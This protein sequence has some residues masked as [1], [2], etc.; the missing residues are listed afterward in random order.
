MTVVD[1]WQGAGEH[2]VLFDGSE[3]PSG[4]YLYSLEAGDIREVRR[5]VLLK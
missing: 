2:E 3:M 1:S 4:I 5:M